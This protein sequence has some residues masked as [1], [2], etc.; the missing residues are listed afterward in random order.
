[1][2]EPLRFLHVADAGLDQPLRD[3]GSLSPAS[4][5][6]AEEA[7]LAA[8]AQM[9]EGAIDRSVNF[10]LLAGN[11]FCEADRSLPARLRLLNGLQK[12]REH[13]IAVFV[14]PGRRDPA[15]AWRA[16]P[17]LP[18]NV[19]VL[20]ADESD[21]EEAATPVAMIR[22]GRVIA[23]ITSGTLAQLSVGTGPPS[24]A[25]DSP[26]KET[27]VGPTPSTNGRTAPTPF[28]VGLLAAWPN[29]PADDA[30]LAERL[31]ACDCDYLA[32]PVSDG[33]ARRLGWSFE[34]GQTLNTDAGIAHHP[35]RLQAD[36]SPGNRTARGDAHRSGQGRRN[37]RHFSPLCRR[38]AVG[39]SLPIEPDATLEELAQAMRSRLEE[40]T[41]QA[42]EHAWF[43]TWILEG[44]RSGF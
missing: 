3:V 13:E 44:Q 29:E 6:L 2:F 21:E 15:S 40:E 19:T 32:V 14:L 4:R 8:F 34:A 37:P 24:S 35:G 25:E 28:R 9:V 30:Q 38:Q 18:P 10:V 23:T 36:L 22:E 20:T 43:V 17:H 39:I 41:A 26:E 7:T 42:G 16:I 27:A 31:S 5:R 33:E 12:L 11:T 1:M